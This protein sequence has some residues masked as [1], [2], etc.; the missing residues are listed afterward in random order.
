MDVVE[1][2]NRVV[3][4]FA[5]LVSAVAADQ[6]PAPTPCT[7]WDVRALV[8]HVVGEERWTAPLMAGRTIAEVGDSLDGD[9]LG[10]EMAAT[11]SI[12]KVHLSYGDEDPHEY[13]RQLAA[14]HLIHGWD[15]AV[16]I[17]V[18]PRM[19]VQV[20]DEVASWFAQREE[21]YRSAGMIG[22]HLDGFSDPAESLLAAS[23][24]DP[25]W[26]P[27]LPVVERFGDAFAAGDLDTVMSYVTDDIV[28]ESTAPPDG[29]RFEGA[30]AVRAEWARLFAETPS[31]RFE[32]EET[33]VLGGRALVRWRYS[34]DEPSGGRGHVRGVDVFRLRNGKIAEN[35]S[36][37]KG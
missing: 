2:H 27:E 22:E 5:E 23:G 29:G 13:L 30:E 16:A 18:P 36:Y 25:R 4:N 6:W 8:N 9:L 31:P 11:W 32:V 33:V 17:G 15:L 34:W 37:V 7:D 26:T 21:L 10:A 3:T 12:G 19:D 35:L 14:D 24:R 28:F 20:V 1:L